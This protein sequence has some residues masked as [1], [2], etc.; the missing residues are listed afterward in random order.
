MVGGGGGGPAGQPPPPHPP[1][2]YDTIRLDKGHYQV[3]DFTIFVMRCSILI[4]YRREPYDQYDYDFDTF[5]LCVWGG[6]GGGL[7]YLWL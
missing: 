2:I 5:F 6:A 3:G 4:W 7:L 1:H